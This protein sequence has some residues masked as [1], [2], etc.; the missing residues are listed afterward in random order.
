MQA[1][2]TGLGYTEWTDFLA[3]IGV[4]V[5]VLHAVAGILVP[6]LVVSFMTRFFGPN[7][8]FAEGVRVWK[9][10]LFASL[11]MTVPYVAAAFLLGPEFPTIL[12]SLFGLTVVVLRGP[13]GLPR[14]AGRGGLGLRAAGEL[15]RGVDRLHR[16]QRPR[17]GRASA[18]RRS[19][20][21][22]PT[23]WWRRSWS[24]PG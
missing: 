15:A 8:S 6:L 5:A 20:R 9:F 4:K 18:W 11:A 3:L 12:G 17:R 2:A 19:G 13:Q 16:P 23:S 14:P 24:S 1:F 10:A 22:C 21:G 7:R